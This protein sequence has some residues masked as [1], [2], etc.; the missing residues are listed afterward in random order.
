MSPEQHGFVKG[1]STSSAIASILHPALDDL[2]KNQ[3]V[4]L[5]FI[6]LSRAFDNVNH[7]KLLE[8]FN[9]YGM[10][11]VSHQLLTSYLQ[12]RL[13]MIL[14]DHL[15]KNN[16][17]KRV[18]SNTSSVKKGT[19]AGSIL[20]PD[21]FNFYLNDLFF[22]IKQKHTDIN[23][24]MA[25]YADDISVK[26]SH[27]SQEEA[28]AHAQ[29]VLNSLH[30]W[31]TANGLPMNC[32]KTQYMILQSKTGSNLNNSPS[33]PSQ[34]CIGSHAITRCDSF[35]LL[36]VELTNKLTW[37]PQVTN[38]TK[39]LSKICYLFKFIR[40]TMSQ[41]SLITV[42]H[43]YFQSVIRYGIQFWGHSNVT[44][45]LI[46]QKR[47]LRTIFRMKPRE[48]CRNVF[49]QNKILTVINLYILEVSIFVHHNKNIFFQSVS[50]VHSYP[51]RN[52]NNIYCGSSHP[53]RY[54][55]IK[56]YNKLPAE[57]KTGTT[58]ACKKYVT[59]LLSSTCFYTLKEYF[60]CKI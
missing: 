16:L 7:S 11:G 8:K 6:D 31:C 40:N 41:K 51:T 26:V 15:D 37:E 33:V 22:Y 23:Y 48:S 34:L 28:F 5:I 18:L 14:I 21:F 49:L 4:I 42:Y 52:N 50:S 55:W 57:A 29:L 24:V 46:M 56:I 45:I 59:K 54:L 25:A 3:T 43:A 53:L 2:H 32:L 17:R 35:S 27:S 10:R 20:G 44:A 13:Q 30:E 38:L 19:F 39:K 47:C 1:K 36:G 9:L 58:K 60:E 12:D